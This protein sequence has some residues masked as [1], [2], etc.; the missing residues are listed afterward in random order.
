V[1]EHR[2]LQGMESYRQNSMARGSSTNSWVLR[3]QATGRRSQGPL[4]E[5]PRNH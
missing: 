1:A 3:S 2:D 5:P 4:A